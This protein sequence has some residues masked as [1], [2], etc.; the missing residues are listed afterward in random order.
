[1]PDAKTLY[2]DAVS[3]SLPSV[4]S[5]LLLSFD[6]FEREKLDTLVR[7]CVGATCP[8][9]I[10]GHSDAWECGQTRLHARLANIGPVKDRKRPRDGDDNGENGENGEGASINGYRHAPAIANKKQKLSTAEDD[11]TEEDTTP[12][13]ILHAL[14]ITAP[15]RKKVDIVITPDAVRLTHP[16]SGAL[17]ARVPVAA[18]TR[19]FLVSS[20]GKNKNKPQ[21]AVTLMTSDRHV[22]KEGFKTTVG[23][24][25]PPASHEK[26]AETLSIL[27]AF[28]A[29]LP[30]HIEQYT[31]L[32]PA[33]ADSALVAFAS[34]SSQ[35]FV[36]AYVG[37]KEGAL[38]FLPSGILWSGTRPCEYFALEDL[39][40]D[41]DVPGAGGVKTLSAT[42]R[43]FSVYVRRGPVHADS[44]N[45]N[46][47]DGEEEE[48]E[49]GEETEFAMIDG[50][51]SENVNAWIRKFRR[52]FG[53][54]RTEQ[55][56][57]VKAVDKKGKGRAKAVGPVQDA[58]DG[59]SD[60][61]DE[62]FVAPSDSD[63]GEPSSDEESGPDGGNND[64]GDEEEEAEDGDSE[65]L[66]DAD[67]EDEELDPARHPLM[68]PGAM[69]RMSKAAM[70]AAVAMVIGDVAGSGDEEEEEEEDELE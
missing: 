45:N 27:Q 3:A 35:P 31:A 58:N 16:V 64:Q 50:R 28:L 9:R 46:S 30:E 56:Q 13:H 38:C 1:M 69:P 20:L 15:V 26:G 23:S 32:G 53:K 10:A 51:E 29:C 21:W 68:R 17:E 25:S 49:E 33:D 67:E 62:D 5:D 18:I 41:S 19:A 24:K 63:G 47:E 34:S 57:V 61:S 11:D 40:P 2:V 42:G 37:A 12:M 54:P 65:D 7:F 66:G 14:S 22:P 52:L 44:G 59:D 55:A 70:D 6:A 4:L 8:P 43:T 36:D 60:R 48:M 39:A